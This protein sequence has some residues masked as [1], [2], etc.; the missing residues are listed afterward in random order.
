MLAGASEQERQVSVWPCSVGISREKSS[1]VI[2]VL[3]QSLDQGCLLYTSE[4]RNQHKGMRIRE[5]NTH[6]RY[7][8][9]IRYFVIREE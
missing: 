8:E 2:Q 3:S 5:G 4:S 9:G 1:K 7:K 6:P